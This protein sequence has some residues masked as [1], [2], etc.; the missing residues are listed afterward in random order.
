L[1]TVHA[2]NSEQDESFEDM[3][4]DYVGER[5]E[6]GFNVSYLLD[7]LNSIKEDMVTLQLKD[8]SSSC[9]IQV[10]M[11]SMSCQHVIMPMRL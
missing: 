10:Q 5:I 6:I 3:T 1:L 2:Q 8:S 7:A 9:L 11:D 4:V